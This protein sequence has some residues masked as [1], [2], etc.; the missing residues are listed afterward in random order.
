MSTTSLRMTAAA[1]QAA[2]ITLHPKNKP[3]VT[4]TVLDMGEQG[5]RLKDTNVR[6]Y[7]PRVFSRCDTKRFPVEF[8][9]R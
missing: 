5:P 9:N 6:R 4:G 3:A 7:F 8:V 2:T 1:Q